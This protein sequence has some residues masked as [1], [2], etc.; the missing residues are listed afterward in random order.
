MRQFKDL[1]PHEFKTLENCEFVV[2]KF[3][4]SLPTDLMK[5]GADIWNNLRDSYETKEDNDI[6]FS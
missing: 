6:F 5:N 4:M 3:V 1:I 2:D